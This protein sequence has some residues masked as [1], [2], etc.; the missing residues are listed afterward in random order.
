MKRSTWRGFRHGGKW[1]SSDTLTKSCTEMYVQ[2]LCCGSST[3]HSFH[4][5]YSFDYLHIYIFL[6]TPTSCLEES[7]SFQSKFRKCMQLTYAQFKYY[8]TGTLRFCTCM[9]GLGDSLPDAIYSWPGPH[10][11]SKKP[12]HMNVKNC[13]YIFGFDGKK[14]KS[15]C[16]L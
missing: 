3:G 10:K 8:A 2:S 7:K 4:I 15:R 5:V 14:Q 1:N 9:I 13:R 12:I 11:S 16:F 6:L